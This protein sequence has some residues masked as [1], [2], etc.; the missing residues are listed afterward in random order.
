MASNVWRGGAFTA[1]VCA[2]AALLALAPLASGDEA[3]IEEP[4]YTV[5]DGKVDAATMT[6]YTVYG[7]ACMACHGPDA[8]GSTFAPSLVQAAGRRTFEQFET[9]LRDGRSIQP[10]QVMP[11]F[12][13]NQRV[14]D[15][16]EDIWR[17]LKARADG[18]LG[19]GRPQPL[20]EGS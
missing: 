4:I 13:D 14:M 10:G 1:A 7:G 17:Y 8:V 18:A 5:V 3:E 20:E 2:V 11:P 15:H 9:V 16:A 6:G 12:A 19:R